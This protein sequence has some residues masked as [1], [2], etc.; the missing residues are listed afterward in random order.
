MLISTVA[1][2]FFAPF[3]VPSV[4]AEAESYERRFPDALG[5][6]AAG[7]AGFCRD[8]APRGGP[9]CDRGSTEEVSWPSAT[10]QR[11]CGFPVTW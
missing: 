4:A 10:R 1:D 3:F 6:R 8:E 7:W 9:E 2:T 11:R 5:V